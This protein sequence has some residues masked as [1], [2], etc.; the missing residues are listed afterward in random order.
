MTT[1][2]REA[3]DALI[4]EAAAIVGRF[5]ILANSGRR[6]VRDDIN[7]SGL[8]QAL[9]AMPKLSEDEPKPRKA[10]A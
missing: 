5:K 1:S 7:V 4:A 9:I 2:E 3:V 10:R 6:I 8:E